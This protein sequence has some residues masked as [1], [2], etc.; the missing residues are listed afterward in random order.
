MRRILDASADGDGSLVLVEQTDNAVIK[1]GMAVTA[2][3]TS[4]KERTTVGYVRE[5]SDR[6]A[7]L[8]LRLSL[9]EI[10]HGADL[11]V[12]VTFDPKEAVVDSLDARIIDIQPRDGCGTLLTIASGRAKGVDRGWRL[13]VIGA[14]NGHG[15]ITVVTNQASRA[16]VKMTPDEVKQSS[17]LV[18]LTPPDR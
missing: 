9:D 5:A 4:M 6:T 3:T 10:Q 11:V 15:T 17:G 7:T 2:Q 14:K 8:A 1:A 12:D 18:R 16:S 13:E